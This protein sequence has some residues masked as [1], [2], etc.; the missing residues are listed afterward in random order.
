MIES[1]FPGGGGGGLQ[2]VTAGTGITVDNTNPDNPVITSTVVDTNDAVKVSSNDTTAG[3]LNGKLVAGSNVTLTENNN[4]GNETLT[5]AATV[6]VTSVNTKTGAV[7]LNATDVGAAATSHTHA[8]TDITSG[9]MATARLGTGTANGTTF[10]AGDQT[11]KT[12][13]Y[14][15][16]SVN[17][18]TGAVTVNDDQV[19]SVTT[20]DA[21]NTTA[22]RNLV[23]FTVFGGSA[24]PPAH[25]LI[26]CEIFYHTRNT[27]G[28]NIVLTSGV[29]INGT[30][31]GT[32]GSTVT[33]GNNY[34]GMVRQWFYFDT[35]AGVIRTVGSGQNTPERRIAG[36]TFI[37]NTPAYWGLD[38]FGTV[39][40]PG[41]SFTIQFTAQWATANANAFVRVLNAR[42]YM[43]RG[44]T[45]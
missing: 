10:L 12:P 1:A 13:P 42:A 28:S 11:Y 29:I 39:A 25:G 31:M 24:A 8:T 20:Q 5:V 23:N 3:F 36:A 35:S 44:Q 9:V 33:T 43:E 6:P 34:Y 26:Y 15:V 22:Q 32:T 18:Q 21:E 16:T 45:T 4:G 14:P 40:N 2:G 37:D 27:S 19:Y 41:T 30:S 17:S 38:F 7:T